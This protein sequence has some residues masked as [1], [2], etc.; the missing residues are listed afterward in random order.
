MLVVKG[1]GTFI[2]QRI[3]KLMHT[4]FRVGKVSQVKRTPIPLHLTLVAMGHLAM[5]VIVTVGHRL[6]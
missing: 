1:A 4:C 6:L 2:T 3:T 5:D